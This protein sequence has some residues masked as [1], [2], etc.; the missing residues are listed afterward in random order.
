ML[1]ALFYER[2][3]ALVQGPFLH[4]IFIKIPGAF[5]TF[6]GSLCYTVPK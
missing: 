4:G 1:L 6:L 3:L 5:M 2:G